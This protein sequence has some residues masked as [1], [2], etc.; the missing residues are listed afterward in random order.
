MIERASVEVTGL[1][2]GVGFRPFVYSLATALDLRGFVQNRGAHVFVDVEGEPSALHAFVDRCHPLAPADHDR[3]VI[4]GS[5]PG[6][7]S[8]VRVPP[9]VATCDE[10]RQEMSD[11]ANRR[12]RHPFITCTS[13]GPRFSIVTKMP[14]D[15]ADTAMGVFAMCEP[16][17]AEYANPLDR[18]FHAQ[19][20][21]CP[22]CGPVLI[23]RDRHAIR[24]EARR[25]WRWASGPCGKAES[26]RSRAWVDSTWHAMPLATKP[27]RN[28]AAGRVVTPS[29]W[30]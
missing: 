20:I 27:S 14:Y 17:R 4:A 19:A 7:D 23:A 30:P 3:F 24:A 22:H 15:R 25:R 5:E 9:D 1:V 18:R 26:W 21:A 10:C 6:S 13:C 16:C 8:A 29:L 12:Y 2:Q 28:Y 11:P